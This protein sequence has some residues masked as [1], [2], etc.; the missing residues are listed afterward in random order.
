MDLAQNLIFYV[1]LNNHVQLTLLD[2]GITNVLG[3]S[4]NVQTLIKI[5]IFVN[6]TLHIDVLTDH[7]LINHQTVQLKLYVHQTDQFYVMT[8]LV[9]NQTHNV[10]QRLNAKL[11]KEDVQMELV[12]QSYKLVEL[13]LPALYNYHIN[14]MTIHAELIHKIVQVYLPVVM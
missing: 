14:A 12:F 9:N 6:L 4:H 5:A 11:E 3:Q 1:Q 10:T 13:Q 8:E 7:V 2:V